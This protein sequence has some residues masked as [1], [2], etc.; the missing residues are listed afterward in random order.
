MTIGNSSEAP[1]A[2]TNFLVEKIRKISEFC[3]NDPAAASNIA[4]VNRALFESEQ[5]KSMLA[6][7]LQEP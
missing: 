3:E 7:L 4:E 5:G 2:L 1:N 6:F